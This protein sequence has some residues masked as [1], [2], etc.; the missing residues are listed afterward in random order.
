MNE[1]NYFMH[2]GRS[3]LYDTQGACLIISSKTLSTATYSVFNNTNVWSDLTVG[4]P[5]LIVGV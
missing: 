4:T 3:P 2:I 5:I 1:L